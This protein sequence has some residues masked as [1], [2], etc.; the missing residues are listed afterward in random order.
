MRA[1]SLGGG[2]R[3]VVTGARLVTTVEVVCEMLVVTA[4]VLRGLPAVTVEVAFE[5]R[6]PGEEQL[7][8]SSAISRQAQLVEKR[9]ASPA[10]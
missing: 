10:R 6:V 8:N 3:G 7:I 5:M 2:A 9:D 4:G 1:Q